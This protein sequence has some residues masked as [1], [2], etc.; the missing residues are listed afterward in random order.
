M[1]EYLVTKLTEKYLYYVSKIM[2]ERWDLKKDV[3]D[4]EARKYLANNEKQ[5]GWIALHKSVPIGVGLFD[6]ENKVLM[7][8]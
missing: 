2:Q 5:A 8:L 1:G 6:I 7:L 4:L 3:A